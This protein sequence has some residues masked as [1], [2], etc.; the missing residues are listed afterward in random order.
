MPK[1][2][3]DKTIWVEGRHSMDLEIKNPVIKMDAEG[4]N[5][6]VD[7]EL[8]ATSVRESWPVFRESS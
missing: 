7:G 8:T 3:D 2:S 5:V 1:K 6:I 4:N